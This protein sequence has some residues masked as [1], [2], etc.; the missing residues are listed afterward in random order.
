MMAMNS[1]DHTLAQTTLSDKIGGG[2]GAKWPPSGGLGGLR[3]T[4]SEC[5]FIVTTS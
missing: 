4:I 1:S 2:G 5:C 3:T